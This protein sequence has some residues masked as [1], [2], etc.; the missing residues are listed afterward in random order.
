M[1]IV[2]IRFLIKEVR[3]EKLRIKTKGA[4]YLKS[5]E[6]LIRLQNKQ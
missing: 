2:G 5:F 1:A 6:M 4:L 3:N